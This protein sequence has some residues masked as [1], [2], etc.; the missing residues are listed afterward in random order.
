MR[1]MRLNFS[2][3]TTDEV[4]LRMGNLQQCRVSE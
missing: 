2:H 3:A 4:E 1:I